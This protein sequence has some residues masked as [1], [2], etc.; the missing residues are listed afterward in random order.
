[1][2]DRLG[3]A[4]L[5]R[6]FEQHKQELY[7]VDFLVNGVSLLSATKACQA[8]IGSEAATNLSLSADRNHRLVG[9]LAIDVPELLEV[10]P[11][12][13]IE[14]LADIDERGLELI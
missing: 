9:A 7:S 13:I 3:V 6:R 5:H 4:L 1:M 11:V 12:E 14:L 10:R 8:R 2:T